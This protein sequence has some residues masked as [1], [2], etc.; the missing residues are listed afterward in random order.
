M[1]NGRLVNLYNAQGTIVL[2]ETGMSHSRAR[3]CFS[4][5]VVVCAF[6]SS[7]TTVIGCREICRIEAFLGVDVIWLVVGGATFLPRY[8][9]ILSNLAC[10]GTYAQLV[11]SCDMF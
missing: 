7:Q 2:R 8:A 3:H 11:L 6:L 10:F 5:I 9:T 4:F 1:C